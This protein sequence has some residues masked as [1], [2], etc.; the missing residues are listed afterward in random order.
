MARDKEHENED[1]LSKYMSIILSHKPDMTREELLKLIEEKS[2]EARVSDSY[3]MIWS[4]F[5]VAHE[6]GIKLEQV[7]SEPTVKI[8]SLTPGLRSVNIVGRVV[9]ARFEK[10]TGAITGER[11]KICRM[12]IGDET[13][14]CHV[15]LWRDLAESAEMQGVGTGDVVK[16]RRGYCK[17]GRFG[18]LEVHAGANSSL[19]KVDEMEGLPPVERFILRLSDLHP[20]LNVVNVE[21]VL[22]SVSPIREFE[23]G[24]GRRGQ[25]RRILVEQDGTDM[26]ASLWDGPASEV[27]E[28]DVGRKVR[29]FGARI[30]MGVDGRV[31]LSLDSGSG[32]VLMDRVRKSAPTVKIK[33]IKPGDVMLRLEAKVVKVFPTSRATLRDIGERA[34]KEMILADE[35]GT[36]NLMIWGV[37]ESS[38]QDVSEGEVVFL[39]GVSAKLRGEHMYLQVGAGGKIRAS[40]DAKHPLKGLKVDI[41]APTRIG[42]VGDGARNLVVEGIV[43]SEVTTVQVQLREREGVKSK[44]SFFLSDDSGSVMVVAWDEDIRKVE[45]LRP[46]STIRVKWCDARY[47]AFSNMLQLMVSSKTRIEM[48]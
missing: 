27:N 38:F 18:T 43:T 8:E 5:M 29:L 13:G 42:E 23:R 11:I 22:K 47:D 19:E 1:M 26:A 35:T 40:G 34:Y 4:I 15:I 30:R 12:A 46:N 48:V 14:W 17:E 20:N 41:E 37:D 24:G 28:E 31:E 6:L 36:A 2:K 25:L 44:A 9:W 7:A 32:V 45:A 10:V 16:L 39:D 21:A 33:D 3:K